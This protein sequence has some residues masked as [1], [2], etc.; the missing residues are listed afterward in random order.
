MKPLFLLLACC[1]CVAGCSREVSTPEPPRTADGL[2][3]AYGAAWQIKEGAGDR[4]F[5]ITFTDTVA[6]VHQ[7]ASG[8]W[9]LNFG[10][11]HPA[12]VLS[13]WVPKSYTK[14]KRREWFA[15][16]TG[17]Q[18]KI[19]GQAKIYKGRPEVVVSNI[20]RDIVTVSR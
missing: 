4:G 3:T 5:E 17:Q 8:Q 1:L 11:P 7:A 15:S 14:E 19:T 9:Y 16:L 18:V 13:V 20:E 10:P 6:A 2:L 12:S